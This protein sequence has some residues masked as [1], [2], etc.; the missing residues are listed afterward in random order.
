MRLFGMG[1]LAEDLWWAGELVSRGFLVV[2]SMGKDEY[3]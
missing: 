1:Q 3:R 2:V